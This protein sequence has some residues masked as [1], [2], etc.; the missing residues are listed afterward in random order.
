MP[1]NRIQNILIFSKQKVAPA[2]LIQG[3]GATNHGKDSFVMKNSVG[4]GDE[5]FRNCQSIMQ[6]TK[7]PIFSLA[8]THEFV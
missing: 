8:C 3:S 7:E 2:G 5:R 6:S 1:N 4:G